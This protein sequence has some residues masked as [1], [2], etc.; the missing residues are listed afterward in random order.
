MQAH[1]QADTANRM[2]GARTWMTFQWGRKKKRRPLSILLFLK[3][4]NAL[5]ILGNCILSHMERKKLQSI[6]WTMCDFLDFTKREKTMPTFNIC[7]CR[8]F[9]T[10]EEIASTPSMDV[11]TSSVKPSIVQS[12]S[13][14]P[15]GLKSKS[16][17]IHC[18]THSH[19][20]NG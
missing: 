11:Q 14:S 10:T 1:N 19:T 17:S 20:L 13:Y 8:N 9:S 7:V 3:L 12:K 4:K 2:S 16:K 6:R 15:I 5:N 18:Y